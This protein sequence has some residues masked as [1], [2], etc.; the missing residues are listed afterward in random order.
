MLLVKMTLW[1]E[2]GIGGS[3]VLLGR[4]GHHEGV[5]SPQSSLCVPETPASTQV[6]SLRT[7]PPLLFQLV[8]P[9]CSL[10]DRGQ[11]PSRGGEERGTCTL[12]GPGLLMARLHAESMTSFYYPNSAGPALKTTWLGMRGSME[13]KWNIGQIRKWES[14][15]S[16]ILNPGGLW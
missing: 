10:P 4:M 14:S 13:G 12:S 11:R 1:E 6:L 8:F 7:Q 5:G 3:W 9:Q 16:E 2:E 15:S